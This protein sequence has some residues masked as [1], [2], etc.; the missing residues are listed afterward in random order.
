MVIHLVER[1]SAICPQPLPPAA[2]AT[3]V[4]FLS[5][6]ELQFLEGQTS[7]DIVQA[8]F[9]DSTPRDDMWG[10]IRREIQDSVVSWSE[11]HEDA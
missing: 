3:G 11:V 9:L 4:F 8:L 1:L 6:A 10:G 5:T 2:F 7:T